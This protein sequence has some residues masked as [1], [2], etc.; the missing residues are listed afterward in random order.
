MSMKQVGQSRIHPLLKRLAGLLH[1]GK[2][3]L[4][5]VLATNGQDDGSGNSSPRSDKLHG[6]ISCF[7]ILT[8]MNN[9][10]SAVTGQSFGDAA[11]D[12]AAG[13]GNE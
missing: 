11:T 13:A 5:G 1:F 3:G 6:F 9:D 4:G 10:H 12:S 2:H 7:E 8:V